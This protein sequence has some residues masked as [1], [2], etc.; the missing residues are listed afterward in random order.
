[1]TKEYYK[2]LLSKLK[3]LKLD[4]ELKEDISD[5]L[6]VALDFEYPQSVGDELIKA[7]NGIMVDNIMHGAIKYI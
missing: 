2:E 7:T 4:K 3:A 1:M 5:A 6:L